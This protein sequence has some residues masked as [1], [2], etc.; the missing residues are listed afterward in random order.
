MELATGKVRWSTDKVAHGGII[1]AG[2]DLFITTDKGEL[3]RVAAEPK[4]FLEKSRAQVLGFE[5]RAQPALADGL[6][7]ARDKGTL[8]AVDLRKQ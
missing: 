4:G 2:N 8:V 5:G 3:V 6:L 7:Y 1:L